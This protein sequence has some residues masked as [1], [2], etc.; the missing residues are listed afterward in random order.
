L[1]ASTLRGAVSQ[2]LV[3]TS[4]GRGRVATCE[5][6]RMT[7]RV[8]DMIMTA[9][10]LSAEEARTVGLYKEVVEPGALMPPYPLF[11]PTQLKALAT[12]LISLK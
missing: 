8:K 2:R 12:Y 1:I 6:L 10:L 5:V 11:K 4:D 3:P 9:R 7:G